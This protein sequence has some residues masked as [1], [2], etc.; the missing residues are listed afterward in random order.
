[1]PEGGT[2]RVHVHDRELPPGAV[3]DLAPGQYVVLEVTDTGVGMSPEVC[4]RVFEPF[5]TTKGPGRGTG[6]GLATSF[7][8]ARQVGGTLTVESRLGEGSTFRLHIPRKVSV[9][10]KPVELGP[11]RSDGRGLSVLVADDEQRIGELVARM[12]E[13]M[14]HQAVIASSGSAALE[15]AEQRHFD[16]VLSDVLMGGDDGLDLLERVRKLR[17]EARLLVMS[18]F[19]PSPERLSALRETGIGFLA[20]PFSFDALRELIDRGGSIPEPEDVE[21][22]Q[23]QP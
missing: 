10:M 8:L 23:A 3:T 15:Q 17:P 12:L 18:G 5:Y 13:L 4:A 9:T 7:G 14:G 16:V 19:S 2:L 22:E 11:P 20:K 21:R 6:L 1:M